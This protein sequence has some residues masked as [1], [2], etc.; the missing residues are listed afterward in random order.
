VKSRTK[1]I[2][3]CGL[4]ILIFG[5][6]L[7]LYGYN[8]TWKLWNIPTMS[9]YFAD[10]RV[11]TGGSESYRQGFD[12]MID[13][14][15]DPWH[16]RLNYPRI[17]QNLYSIG[18][19]QSHTIYIGVIFILLFLVGVC[20]FLPHASNIIIVLVM[21]AVLSP[22]T[23]LGIER[24]NI[25]LFMF[26]LMSISIVAAKSK[27]W[28]ILSAIAV[29]LGFILKLF[30]IFGCA[31]LLRLSRSLFLKYILVILVIATLYV[32]LTYSDILLIREVTEIGTYLSY[33]SNVFWM[34][35]MNLNAT[36]GI[37]ARYFTYL[38][39]LLTFGLAFF[40]FSRDDFLPEKTNDEAYLDAFRAG[41]AIYIGTF[42]LG[43]NWDYRLMFLIFTIPQLVLWAKCSTRYISTSSIVI[44][45]SIYSSLW[46]LIMARITTNLPHG[47]YVSFMLD[48]M[49]NW[50]VFSGLLYLFFWSMPNWVK[51]MVRK[52]TF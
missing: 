16:R 35:A 42:L 33:G 19:N 37:Y 38:T 44:L 4:T 5:A 47:Y 10:I 15:G 34:E 52:C 20:V 21:A 40:A 51:N 6:L 28:H 14:P 36:T 23:L 31:V 43:N 26:F 12:P 18:I 3:G 30:P 49:S 7:S 22:A 9:P 45:S 27:R 24:G 13:N 48:E 2:M 29:L 32:S 1:I 50:I 41:S 25:D 17:W 11:V 8:N 46:F 39:V